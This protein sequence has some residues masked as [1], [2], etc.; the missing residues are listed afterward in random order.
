M[1]DGSGSG[2]VGSIATDFA[3]KKQK[4]KKEKARRIIKLTP[5][6]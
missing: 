4:R 5:N 3:R 1:P 6:N 2:H